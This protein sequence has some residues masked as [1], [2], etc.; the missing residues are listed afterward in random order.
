MG[1]LCWILSFS[2]L[3]WAYQVVQKTNEVTI[4]GDGVNPAEISSTDGDLKIQIGANSYDVFSNTTLKFNIDSVYLQGGSF[5]IRGSDIASYRLKTPVGSIVVS[6]SDFLFH[7]W[8]EKA[9]A[10][11]EVFAGSGLI[12]GEFHEEVLN[13]QQGERGQFIGVPEPDGPAFDVLLKGRKSIRGSLAGPEKLTDKQIMDLKE[14][15]N[16]KVR[17]VAKIVKPKPKPGQICA[18][19]F[20]KFNECAW[21]CRNNSVGK[22]E[23]DVQNIKVDCVREKCLANG[24]WGDTQ[25]LKG[26]A[27]RECSS[28]G[29]KVSDCHY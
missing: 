10:Q 9:L 29:V 25:V 6:G 21:R 8:P 23:C 2:P 7:Y 17:P 13:V 16:I 26:S 24:Q 14:E 28:V 3:I 4:S 18:E 12:Q 15:F 5:R 1:I 20:A 19:P 11:V 22:K 27:K